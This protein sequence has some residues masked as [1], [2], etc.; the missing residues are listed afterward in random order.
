MKKRIILCIVLVLSFIFAACGA[1]KEAPNST[2]S[3]NQSIAVKPDR[4]SEDLAINGKEDSSAADSTEAGKSK[5]TSQKSTDTKIIR[6]GTIYIEEENLLKLEQS[7]E[8]KA[9]EL[10]GYIEGEQVNEYSFQA[11]VRIPAQ[12]L[13]TFISYTEK[14]F[15]VKSKSMS[16][17]NITDA[18]V[19][20]EARLT[21][22]K[23]QEKQILEILKKAKTVEEVLKVQSEL[24]K[25]RGDIEA[26]EAQKKTWDKLVAY[27]AVTINADK[28]QII[29]DNKKTIISGSEFFKAIGKGFN[30]TWISLI[31]LIQN[32]IIF[33]FSNIIIILIL[34]LLGVLGYRYYRKYNK[35]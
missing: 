27:A 34:V 31:L 2:G 23:A 29:P 32:L 25:V 20:N 18:Y 7:L 12:K 16:S 30:N 35:K 6:N 5:S 15:T 22:L 1:K 3:A 9:E 28:K 4:M 8:K 24:Y 17:E 21:N 19:D 13:D 10:G 11:V 26:L 14:G 33:V